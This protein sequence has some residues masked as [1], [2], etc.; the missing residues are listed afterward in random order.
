M[1]GN[2]SAPVEELLEKG[3]KVLDVGCGS[4]RWILEM[5][6]DFPNSTFIGVDVSNVF[7]SPDKIP[8]NASFVEGNVLHGLPFADDTF[9]YVYQR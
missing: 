2:F 5:A 9:D 1:H 8:S 3:I 4:G 6:R 7:P